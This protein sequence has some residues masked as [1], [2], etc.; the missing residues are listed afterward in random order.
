MLKTPL[1]IVIPTRNRPELL[2]RAIASITSQGY[3]NVQ[4]IVIDDCS[5][6]DM[7]DYLPEPLIGHNLTC[8]RLLQHSGPCIARNEGIELALNDWVIMLDDDDELMPDSLEVINR[9]INLYS[10]R[11]A[12][13]PVIM[14]ASTAM[15]KPFYVG[16]ICLAHF[17]KGELAGELLAVINRPLFIAHNLAYP[18]YK[19][20]GES[21]LWWSVA[22]D[23]ILPYMPLPILLKINNDAKSRLT[24]LRNRIKRANEYANFHKARIDSFREILVCYPR[25]WSRIHLS[26]AFYSL[27]AMKPSIA[28]RYLSKIKLLS[29]LTNK[30]LNIF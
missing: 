10:Q 28:I 22:R 25:K 4:I 27:I 17:L 2:Q 1:S 16:S 6:M 5:D 15:K 23:Y 18:N 19:I 26:A 3:A 30:R 14:F 20:G 13:Y 21:L 29:A 9:T 11:S 24:H 12:K 8:R 7:I